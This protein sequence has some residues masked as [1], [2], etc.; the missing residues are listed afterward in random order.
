MGLFVF[1]TKPI[2]SALTP[3][4]TN[5]AQWD[6]K[7]KGKPQAM[8]A[9]FLKRIKPGLDSS[10]DMWLSTLPQQRQAQKNI[11]DLATPGGV[12][13]RVSGVRRELLGT[14]RDQARLM[15]R[16]FAGSGGLGLEEG[17]TIEGENDANRQANDLFTY[18]NTPKGQAELT[19]IIMEMSSKF[20]GMDVF[21]LLN[22]IIQGRPAPQVGP[23]PI[24][25]VGSALGLLQRP[26]GKIF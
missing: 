10:L 15:S 7:T 20:P 2:K 24:A 22:S 3:A 9:D 25:G 8:A 12:N 5:A 18:F 1:I 23:S 19:N 16:K 26:S 14:A 4:G 17:L 11:F 13:R 6:S 21:A